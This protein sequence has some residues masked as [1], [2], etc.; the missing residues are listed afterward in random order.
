MKLKWITPLF[1]IYAGLF[2]HEFPKHPPTDYHFAL[3]PNLLLWDYTQADDD[4]VADYDWGKCDGLFQKT[5]SEQDI[6]D[7]VHYE[8]GLGVTFKYIPN[9]EQDVEFRFLGLL[10]WWG[11]RTIGKNAEISVP[12]NFCTVDWSLADKLQSVNTST[13]NSYDITWWFHSPARKTSY[14]AW[15]WG[16]GARYMQIDE[17]FDLTVTKSD[18]VSIYDID[19]HNNLMAAQLAGEF[20]VQPYRFVGWGFT[21]RGGIA[22]DALTTDSY[23]SDNND[24]QILRNARD[25]KVHI[26]WLVECNP[27]LSIDLHSRATL[28]VAYDVVYAQGVALASDQ[29]YFGHKVIPLDD[30]GR[31]GVH[32]L[33][34]GLSFQF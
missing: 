30:S 12:F 13:F 17:E 26:C 19:S 31:V 16:V 22:A 24:S 15:G 27:F 11:R 8:P 29:L 34:A 10:K 18:R 28:R 21:V 5:L 3:Y 9:G 14:F 2:A 6:L 23:L 1:L 25:S 7:S 33:Q 20:I 4:T 32:G